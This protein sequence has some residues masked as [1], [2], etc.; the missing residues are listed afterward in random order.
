MHDANECSVVRC[1]IG[2]DI[3]TLTIFDCFFS[4]ITVDKP[5]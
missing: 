4:K 3:H 2:I 1:A 5:P